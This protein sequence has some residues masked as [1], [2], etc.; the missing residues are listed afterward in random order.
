MVGLD[1][2]IAVDILDA[3]AGQSRVRVKGGRTPDP[4][5]GVS[6]GSREIPTALAFV[7][8]AEAVDFS[9]FSQR[10]NVG[11][12]KS[13]LK[14]GFLM[15]HFQNDFFI[16]SNLDDHVAFEFGNLAGGKVAVSGVLA[17]DE[18]LAVLGDDGR[19]AAVGSHVGRGQAI[20]LGQLL[21]LDGLRLP[22]GLGLVAVLAPAGG[23][24]EK[25]GPVFSKK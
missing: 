16:D 9:L 24:D 22:P 7:V 13:G 18:Q 5:G 12:A 1:V 21:G 19:G 20:H 2:V 14:I 8:H 10:H 11:F 6:P 17:E 15:K 4:G 23:A 3:V 25:Y